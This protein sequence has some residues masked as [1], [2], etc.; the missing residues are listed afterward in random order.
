[1]SLLSVLILTQTKL[2]D[3]LFLEENIR[4]NYSDD[5]SYEIEK[6]DTGQSRLSKWLIKS[7]EI[8]GGVLQLIDEDGMAIDESKSSKRLKETYQPDDFKALQHS[9][10]T[11]MWTLETGE[12]ILF[13]EETASDIVVDHVEKEKGFPKV[14]DEEFLH[15]YGR[16][17]EIYNE[18]G[19]R[20]YGLQN[21]NMKALL[22]EEVMISQN[23]SQENKENIATVDLNNG[24]IVIV[25]TPNPHY[26]SY[27]DYM[28][29]IKIGRASCRERV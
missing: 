12:R 20:I 11:Y 13:I 25:R 14:G 8:S 5:F 3:N 10:D 28:F 18:A 16:S 17:E 6:D 4:N 7:A 29:M 21:E 9:Q 15:E 23:H 19:D 24:D 2:V 26:K 22:L 27:E 1:M